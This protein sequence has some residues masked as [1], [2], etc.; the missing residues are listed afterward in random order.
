MGIA[1]YIMSRG[2]ESGI[3]SEVGCGHAIACV[4]GKPVVELSYYVRFLMFSC[5]Q[6]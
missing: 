5:C 3:R 1:Q 2:Q 6:A 4:G